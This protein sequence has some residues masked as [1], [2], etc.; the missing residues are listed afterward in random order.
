MGACAVGLH[1]N[2]GE[3]EQN[4]RLRM[5][6]LASTVAMILAVIVVKLDLWAGYRVLMFLPFLFAANGVYMGLYR[7]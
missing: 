4:R 7:T 1:G 3:E 2:L 6:V 5:G